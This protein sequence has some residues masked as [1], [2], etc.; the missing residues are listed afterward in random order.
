ML[1]DYTVE[2]LFTIGT[3]EKEIENQR[4]KAQ[5]RSDSPLTKS[6]PATSGQTDTYDFHTESLW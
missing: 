1:V 2:D 6:E 5:S 4:D 3:E